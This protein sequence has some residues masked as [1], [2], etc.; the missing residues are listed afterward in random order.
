LEPD[1]VRDLLALGW[2]DKTTLQIILDILGL[3]ADAPAHLV[4]PKA[5]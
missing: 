3:E 5:F 4:G 1:D 2:L